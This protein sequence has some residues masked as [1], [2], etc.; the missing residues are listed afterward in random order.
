MKRANEAHT[1]ADAGRHEQALGNLIGNAL[2]CAPERSEVNVSLR[3]SGGRAEKRVSDR[4]PVIDPSLSSTL[5]E[6]FAQGSPARAPSP[7]GSASAS[8]SRARS[9]SYKGATL[10]KS[11]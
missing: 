4:G 2:R 6:P 7:R 5:F 9:R 8:G 1:T 11:A 3:E 10:S